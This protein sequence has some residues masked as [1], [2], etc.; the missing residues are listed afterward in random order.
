[1]THNEYHENTIGLHAMSAIAFLHD[2]SGKSVLIF[3][4]PRIRESRTVGYNRTK[5][6]RRNEPIRLWVGSEARKYDIEWRWVV[7]HLE[8]LFP[9][10]WKTKLKSWIDVIMLAAI[11]G[12]SGPGEL[13]FD[14]PGVM[15]N[16]CLL[17]NY[18]I[19]QNFDNG[20]GGAWGERKILGDGT[21]GYEYDELDA[22]SRIITVRISLESQYQNI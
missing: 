20:A 8:T 13:S 22:F 16:G 15:T 9:D 12:N 7:P 5:I 21:E 17:T 6:Y 11:G 4:N 10:T 19:E 2:D 3:E 18:E 14:A 1:M